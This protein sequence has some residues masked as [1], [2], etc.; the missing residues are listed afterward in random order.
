MTRGPFVQVFAFAWCALLFFT[1]GPLALVWPTLAWRN[2]ISLVAGRLW[3]AACIRVAGIR[4]VFTGRER[5]ALAPAIYLFN[6]TNTLDFFVNGLVARPGW[7]VFGKR[8]LAWLPFVGW[9]WFLGGHP[10]VKRGDRERWERSLAR[11]EGL[12]RRGWCTIVAPEGTRSRD[13]RLGPF[14]KGAF[15]LA[16][17]TGA[18][19][20]PVV[21]RGAAPLFDRLG[22][23]PGTITVDVLEPVDPRGWTADALDAHIDE[24]RR[25]FQAALGEA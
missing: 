23:R 3:C 7:L 4:V 15:H 25:R 16:L 24:V 13:G 2:R 9:G 14:K 22:P 1:L 5:L 21:I 17:A 6:H 12:L 8:E 19:L 10:L 11:V 18:P 20:V